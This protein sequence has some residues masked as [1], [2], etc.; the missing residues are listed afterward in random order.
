MAKHHFK[1]PSVLLDELGINT[2][3]QIN[4]ELIAQYCGAT[5]LY[6]SLNSCEA[7]LLGKAERAVICIN[8]D[9]PRSRQR[10]SIGH[11]LGHWMHDRG[12]MASLYLSEVHVEE[13]SKAAIEKRANQYAKELLMPT[14][15][16]SPLAQRRD[17]TFA[18]VKDLARIFETSL[19]ATAI[20][21]VELSSASA[22]LICYRK[23]KSPW[24][25]RSKSLPAFNPLKTPGNSTI[26]HQILAGKIREGVIP[27]V[28]LE[29]C[30]EPTKLPPSNVQEH[31]LRITEDA[32]L[33]L[34]WWKGESAV[35]AHR[36]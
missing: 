7:Y 29:E 9:A 17:M 27:K 21:L 34:L 4:L 3:E 25:F 19:T 20:R 14:E 28:A 26:A 15:I 33:T 6:E 16:F 13:W 11:E 8:Q 24:F 35:L 32:V 2:P 30:L 31:S 5:V 18:T 36:S 1:S 23:Q 10:F 22:M 12:K